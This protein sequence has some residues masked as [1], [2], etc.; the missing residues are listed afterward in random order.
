MVDL[1][2]HLLFDIDDGP[3]SIDVSKKML[4]AMNTIGVSTAVCTP[5]FDFTNI[6]PEQFVEIR[7]NRIKAL[8]PFAD[9]QN[10]KLVKG[11]EL[12]LTKRILNLNSID[13]F[14]IGDTRNVLVEMPFDKEWDK[15]VFELIINF[16]DYFN[17]TPIIAHVERYFPV[18][19]DI[20]VAEK[21]FDIGAII[22]LD[23][24]S[25]FEKMYAKTAKKLLK[26][27]LV[28]VVASD[29][30]NVSLRSPCVLAKAYDEIDKICKNGAVEYIKN[31][32]QK[33]VTE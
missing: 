4:A 28:A 32:A 27:Q 2:T 30:H 31:F 14:C 19:K 22:Q 5:H 12:R 23:A 9:K 18:I 15:S 25:L 29:C 16:I 10:I 13:D 26:I 24:S 3:E 17:V 8:I 7:N 1:H 6:S 11:C 20:N 21:L 33:I